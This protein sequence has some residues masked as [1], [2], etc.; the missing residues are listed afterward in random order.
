MSTSSWHEQATVFECGGDRLIGI[1]TA[2]ARPIETGV[3]IIVG[4]PQYR[5]GSHRQ[6]TLLARQLAEQGIASFRFDYR[7]MGDSEGEM[8]NFEAIDEDI[9]AAIETFMAHVASVKEVVLWGLC[10]AASAAL[11]YGH[12]DA[13]VSG[14]VLLNPWVHS[15]AGAARVR[16]KHYYLARLLSKSF[17]AKLISGKIRIGETIGDLKKSTRNASNE[18]VGH[19]APTDAPRHGGPGYIDRMLD[20]LKRFSGRVQVILSGNDLTAQEFI[21]LTSNDKRWKPVC[22]GV[23]ISRMFIPGANHTFSSSN[24]RRQVSEGTA[25][26]IKKKLIMGNRKTAINRPT[27]PTAGFARNNR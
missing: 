19:T 22:D 10:D 7:G 13:R 24:W 14:M 9:R 1:V 4:G 26:W 27:I 3:V 5:A 16:L 20:D 17:W 18:N 23:N 21:E 25:N 12:T 11:Y 15:E 8:R 2:T 6:F